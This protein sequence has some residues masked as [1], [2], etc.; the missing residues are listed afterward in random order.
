MSKELDVGNMPIDIEV[1]DFQIM[2]HESL[3]FHN[4]KDWKHLD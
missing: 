1:L 3:I 2:L 4:C